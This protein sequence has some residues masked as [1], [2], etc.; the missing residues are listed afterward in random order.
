MK[1]WPVNTLERWVDRW[2]C[3]VLGRSNPESVYAAM[4]RY[5]ISWS[6]QADR[7]QAEMN[8]IASQVLEETCP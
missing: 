1:K 7:E 2:V 5:Q 3:E 4:V 6:K 8:I